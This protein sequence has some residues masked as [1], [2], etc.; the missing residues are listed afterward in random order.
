[1]IVG[2]VELQGKYGISPSGE[3][4]EIET[5]VLDAPRFNQRVEVTNSAVEWQGTSG[6]YA[7]KQARLIPK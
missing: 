2:L 7:I 3:G 5:T 6:V 4:G 1:M